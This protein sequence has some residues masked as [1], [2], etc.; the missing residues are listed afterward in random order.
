MGGKKH[1]QMEL[2]TMNTK[3]VLLGGDPEAGGKPTGPTS[4]VEKLRNE[5]QVL[6]VRS[7]FCCLKTPS[8]PVPLL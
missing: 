7:P 1:V 3:N 5:V 8:V 4:E 2:A 6:R